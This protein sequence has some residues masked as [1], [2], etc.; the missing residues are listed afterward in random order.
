M[1]TRNPGHAN[2]ILHPGRRKKG[3]KNK[4]TRTMREAI[5]E[6]FDQ[7]GGANGLAKWATKKYRVKVNGKWV[8][9]QPNLG[10][11]YEMATKLIPIHTN[12]SGSVCHYVATPIPIE[13]RDPLPDTAPDA[14]RLFCEN[15]KKDEH[16]ER[17]ADRATNFSA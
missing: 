11:F 15:N 13:E 1:S 10:L 14:P 9:R 8:I 16:N 5:L 7:L 2:I 17:F 3:V 12:V 4:I 6:A